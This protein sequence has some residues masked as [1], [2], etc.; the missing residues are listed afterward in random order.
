MKAH[1][2]L[3]TLALVAGLSAPAAPRNIVL[4]VADD[5]GTD[6]G[7]YGHPTVQSPHI[8]RLA[9]EGVRFTH[10]CCTT[11]SCSPSRSVLLSGRH[12][13]AN[14]MYGLAH[15]THHFASFDTL[16]T[17]PA[18]LAAAG[19]RT[20]RMGQVSR[21]PESVYLW[22]RSRRQSGRRPQPVTMAERCREFLGQTADTAILPLL[23][24]R[25]STPSGP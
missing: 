15:A 21:Q 25:R 18:L 19:Y 2:L 23:L 10:A 7:C 5:L 4:V 14:G 3:C 24:H 12:N 17:L 16:K 11:A 6:L 9:R 13:H 8:D 1:I 22:H 20:A